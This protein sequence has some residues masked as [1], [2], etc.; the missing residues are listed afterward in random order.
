[1][2]WAG[3]ASRQRTIDMVG[4]TIHNAQLAQAAF[5]LA[6]AARNG[7]RTRVAFVNAHAVNTAMADPATRQRSHRQIASMPMAAAWPL[8][9]ALRASRSPTTSTANGTDLFPELRQQAIAQGQRIFLLGRRPGIASNAAQ[10]ITE[11]GMAEAL[12]GSHHG[13]FVSGTSDEDKVIAKINAT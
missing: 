13:Y 1:M 10:T 3:S 7:R 2:L 8:R 5:D 4:L 9:P 6:G 12:A 11:F